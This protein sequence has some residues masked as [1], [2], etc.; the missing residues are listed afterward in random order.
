MYRVSR[1][2]ARGEQRHLL[3]ASTKNKD[4]RDKHR[5]IETKVGTNR[6]IKTNTNTDTTTM[7][8]NSRLN[9]QP[10]FEKSYTSFDFC[11]LSLISRKKVNMASR[12]ILCQRFF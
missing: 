4:T 8:T 6:D 10:F 3:C 5:D 11:V 7:D 2:Y 1:R 12:N 9:P